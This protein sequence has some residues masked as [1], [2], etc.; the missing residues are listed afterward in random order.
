[1]EAG[2]VAAAHPG[3]VVHDGKGRCGR[4]GR[5]RYGTG[6]GVERVG[7]DLGEDRLLEAAGVGVADV[8]EQVQEIDAGLAHSANLGRPGLRRAHQSACRLL[9]ASGV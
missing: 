8:L 3:A 1:V 4:V 9:T 5:E 7:D 6:A 2:Q